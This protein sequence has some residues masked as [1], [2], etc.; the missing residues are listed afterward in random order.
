MWRHQQH[1]DGSRAPDSDATIAQFV[2]LWDDV[3]HSQLPILL[4]RGTAAGTIVDDDALAELD[5]RRPDARVVAV[6]G[7][8]HSVQGDQP[9]VLAAILEELFEV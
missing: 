1:W 5:R 8:G 9:L 4:V 2:L 6:E 7:A 3:E